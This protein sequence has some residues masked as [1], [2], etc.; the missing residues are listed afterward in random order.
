[1]LE[2]RKIGPWSWTVWPT[3]PMPTEAWVRAH[4]E[5]HGA[6][7]TNEFWEVREK[8]IAQ[9]RHDPLHWGW[10]APPIAIMRALYAGTYKPGMIG[11]PAAGVDREKTHKATDLLAMA[12][13]RGGKSNFGGKFVM[14][15]LTSAPSKLV[16]CWSQNE[17]RSITEQQRLVNFH[18]PPAYRGKKKVGNVGK[19]SWS[20]ATGFSERTFVLPL[21]AGTPLNVPGSQCLFMT[22]H[23]WR[24]DKTVAEGGEAD[25]IWCDE[26]VPGELLDT[27]RFRTGQRR[28]LLLVTF[29]PLQGYTEAVGH[30]LEA[31]EILETVPARRIVWDWWQQTWAWGDWI[32]PSDQVLV[33][34]CPPGHVP[35]VLKS[36]T[37]ERY[38]V[39]FGT[40]WNPYVPLDEVL[41]KVEAAPL[42]VKLT[43]LFGWPT[44]RANKAFER[45]GAAHIV[46]AE[47]VPKA[48]EMD[49][50]LFA[51]P[52]GDRNWF[53]LWLGVDAA[54][55][56]WAIAEWPD[57]SMG[58]W[59]L[60]GDKPDGKEGPAQHCGGGKCFDDYK[61]IIHTVEGWV[62]DEAGAMKQGPNAW[63]VRDRRMDPRPAGTSVPS[64]S[65]QRTYLHFMDEPVLSNG[66]EIVPGVNFI[67]APGCE[68]DEGKSYIN[69]MLLRGWD[70]TAPVT[71]LNCPKFYVSEAC[72]NL[73]WS[74]KTWTGLDGQKGKSKDPI[75]CLKWAAKL[76]IWENI[77][78]VVEVTG[79]RGER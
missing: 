37:R 7:K 14:Q 16:R 39:V 76:K 45:F 27:L 70:E 43:R 30:Y 65:E 57:A 17:E 38:A 77:P 33:K 59:A 11:T 32:L 41:R 58:E 73:I 42:E 67:A 22:Y 19:I 72:P 8:L 4:I 75:D 56:V 63:Q 26:E 9:E 24:G 21:P 79:G 53:M 36:A 40:C 62:Y 28:M 47:R 44:R 48:S 13:N 78:G 18:M 29:T 12:G 60:P 1:M 74:L 31:A 46:P 25:L 49:I 10:E 64:D 54:G 20:Q 5:R 6:A 3:R 66:K 55:T 15:T 52:A 51:D 35:M 68:V 34:G 61:R 71:P 23:Q 2:Q 50:Y 69:D